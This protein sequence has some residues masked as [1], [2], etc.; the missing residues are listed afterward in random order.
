M[1]IKRLAL[2]VAAYL[3][4]GSF[5]T[6]CVHG[7]AWAHCDNAP[8]AI[9]DSDF[10]QSTFAWPLGISAAIGEIIGSQGKDDGH[11]GGNRAN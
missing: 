9:S 1:G 4:F 5:F 3:F 10:W 7:C 8:E 6:G 11:C 2:Y